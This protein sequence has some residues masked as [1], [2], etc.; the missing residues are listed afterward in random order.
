MPPI[1]PA[2]AQTL[3]DSVEHRLYEFIRANRL[4]IGDVLPGEEA[5]A[6]TL[7]VSRHIVREALSRLKMLGLVESRKRRGMELVKPDPF[8]G[9]ERLATANVLDDR[10]Q[11]ELLELRVVMEL[12]M[13]DYVSARVTAADLRALA[14]IVRRDRP[15]QHDLPEMDRV[16][17]QFHAKLYQISGNETLRRLQGILQPFLRILRQNKKIPLRDNPHPPS[18]RELY[19]WLKKGDAAGFRDGMR[20]HL[21]VYLPVRGDKRPRSTAPSRRKPG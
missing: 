7:R 19:E 2:A 3:A 4:G 16:E 9:L 21:E 1:L 11:L 18:H 14:E 12:G 5:L 17:Y 6:A 20:R 8:I 13:C 15:E 10:D